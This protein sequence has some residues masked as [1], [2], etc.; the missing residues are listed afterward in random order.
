MEILTEIIKSIGLKEMM[1]DGIK[2]NTLV[3]LF[4]MLAPSSLLYV[5][6]VRE[7]SALECGAKVI[8]GIVLT[9]TV[10]LILLCMNTLYNMDKIYDLDQKSSRCT[11][12]KKEKKQV[13]IY[14]NKIYMSIF[15]EEF[16]IVTT[17]YMDYFINGNIDSAISFIC[18]IFAIAIGWKILKLICMILI[19]IC[20]LLI[21]ICMI[22]IKKFSTMTGRN[23]YNNITGSNIYYKVTNRFRKTTGLSFRKIMTFIVVI[24]ALSILMSTLIYYYIIYLSKLI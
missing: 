4:I 6:N 13:E 16:I 20:S 21:K 22:L 3:T 14:K 15:A 24:V 5:F 18:L 10:F 2:A 11:L 12:S 7:Y 17:I 8:I 23:I 19:K 9:I 1:K